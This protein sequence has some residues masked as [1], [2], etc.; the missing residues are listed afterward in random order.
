MTITT[1]EKKFLYF[2]I[3]Y[4]I[5]FT[6][7]ALWHGN[8]EFL[9]Y[10][11]VMITLLW[12]IVYTYH[13]V[14]LDSWIA[15]SLSILGLMH[16]TGGN[17]S[18]AGIRLYDITIIPGWIRYDNIVHSFGSFILTF[19]AFNL[20]H[21]IIHENLKIKKRMIFMGLLVLVSL[22]VGSINEMIE[23]FAVTFLD[24]AQQVGDYQNNAKDLV[25]NSIGAM[26]ASIIIYYYYEIQPR[27]N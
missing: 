7:S 4:I 19:I 11:G 18:I 6:L 17:V 26:T 8:I 27:K 20:L 15:A 1:K 12:I 13:R 5:L 21:P 16:L 23:F 3:A 25:F 24:A 14:S 22:G 10:S 2:T 9:Y